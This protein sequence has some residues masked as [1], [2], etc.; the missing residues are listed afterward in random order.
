M[1]TRERKSW[2]GQV[3]LPVCPLVLVRSVPLFFSYSHPFFIFLFFSLSFFSCLVSFV[4]SRKVSIVFNPSSFSYTGIYIYPSLPIV[5]SYSFNL[6][7][8][9]LTF[10]LDVSFVSVDGSFILLVVTLRREPRDLIE[11]L[12]IGQSLST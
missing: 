2:I 3:R 10:S 12:S 4:F 6:M 9:N 5:L 1:Q 7:R 11:F 8:T